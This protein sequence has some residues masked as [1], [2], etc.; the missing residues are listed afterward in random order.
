MMRGIAIWALAACIS[1]LVFE[2]TSFAA[3]ELTAD[4][5]VEKNVAAR[6]GAEA[7]RKVQTMVWI[8]HVESANAIAPSLPFVLELKRPNKERFE[9][10]AQ[11]GISVRMYDGTLGWKLRPKQ[12]GRPELQP[13]TA[14]E[15]SFAR[16]EQVIDGPL[17]DYA[18]KGIAV[19]LDGVDEIEG[20]KAYRMSVKLPSGTSQHVWIDAQSFLD[21]KSDRQPANTHGHSGIVTEFYRNYRTI[22]GLQI[23]F[24]IESSVDTTKSTD[25]M[26][27]DKV[28]LNQSLDDR[29]FIKPGTPGRRSMVSRGNSRRAAQSFLSS[30]SSLPTE[31]PG[32]GSRSMPGFMDTRE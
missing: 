10:Q 31:F 14:D 28:M 13:Y 19:A 9:V 6:G 8:G 17:I 30:T 15:L 22:E 3:P 25:R 20:H 5:I 24:T 2:E 7:W 21:I 23:P 32:Q 16:D 26:V 29:I 18:A 1:T 4:Q 11:N 12:G 27:I